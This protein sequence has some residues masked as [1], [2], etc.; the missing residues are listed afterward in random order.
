MLLLFYLHVQEVSDYAT[1]KALVRDDEVGL[2]LE[3]F[4][5]DQRVEDPLATVQVRFPWKINEE[6]TFNE[7]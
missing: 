7:W 6:N 2:I 3:A 4:D 1:Q 5:A